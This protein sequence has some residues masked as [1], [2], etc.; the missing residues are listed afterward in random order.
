MPRVWPTGF[1][2]KGVDEIYVCGLALDY[3]VKYTVLDGLAEGFR[4]VLVEDA[5]RAVDLDRGDGARAVE[6][7]R[8]RRSRGHDEQRGARASPVST[9]LLGKSYGSVRVRRPVRLHA[10]LVSVGL[11]DFTRSSSPSACPTSREARLRR[12]V[13]LHAK[14][15]SVGLSDFTRSSSP[16]ACPTSR[17]ARLRRPGRRHAKRF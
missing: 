13:R 11:S 16:S 10:K 14:L 6:V 7:M 8:T 9:G 3:C 4:T 5:C 15:V 12:P 2:R 1:A 17:E